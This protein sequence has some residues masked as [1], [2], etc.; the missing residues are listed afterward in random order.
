LELRDEMMGVESILEDVI[1]TLSIL[2]V[3]VELLFYVHREVPAKLIGDSGK[4]R[5]IIMNLVGKRSG[6]KRRNG[7]GGRKGSG[8]VIDLIFSVHRDVPAKLSEDFG[9]LRQKLS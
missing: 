3:S 1:E 5:Q 8:D 7:S 4:L 6:K 2:A 9:K